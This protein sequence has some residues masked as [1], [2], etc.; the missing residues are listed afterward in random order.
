[1]ELINNTKFEVGF[2]LGMDAEARER[3]V[4]VAKG[5]YDLPTI[6]CEPDLAAEQLPLV[7]ADEFTGEPGFS[8]TVHESDFAPFKPRCDVVLN[9]SAYAPQGHAA[10][11]VTVGLRVATMRKSFSVVGPRTWKKS[12][13]S[14][15]PS[16]PQPF[17]QQAIGYDHAY[18]GRDVSA[19]NPDKEKSYLDNPV[20]TGFYPLTSRSDLVGK[21]LPNSSELGTMITTRKGK[22]APQSFGVIGRNFAAR[23]RFAGTYDQAWTDEVFPFLPVDFDPR[24]HQSAPPE[25]QI[26][27]PR[28]GEKVV[29]VNLTSQGR[30][31]FRL[32]TVEIP[33]RFTDE[34]GRQSSCEAVIDTVIIEPD[35]GRLLLVWRASLALRRDIHELKRCVA[36]PLAQE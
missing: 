35:M 1:M 34:D 31:V 6:D 5:T 15:K 29:L 11:E 33:V 22:N 32:P 13:M 27:Y 18:G 14:V 2:T 36:G 21:P 23:H 7:L 16:D 25:Q 9:G 17:V 19:K 8:A 10:R 28:G 24:Y 12:L 3:V 20:G 26:E 4:V 30:N